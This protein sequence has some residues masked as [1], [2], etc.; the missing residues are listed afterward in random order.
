MAL[1]RIA[2]ILC[3]PCRLR[4]AHTSNFAP[5][6]CLGC[7]SR[8][9]VFPALD[10]SSVPAR[11]VGSVATRRGVE[12]ELSYTDND[13]T[14]SDD[15][16]RALYSDLFASPAQPSIETHEDVPQK[17]TLQI[18]SERFNLE[19]GEIPTYKMV[20]GRI[21]DAIAFIAPDE[22]ASPQLGLVLDSEWKDVIGAALD[23][24]DIN[25]ALKALT[26]MKSSNAVLP[27]NTD[28]HLLG[29]SY[30][31]TNVDHFTT[32]S[33]K[34]AQ[35]GYP[36][37]PDR[38]SLFIYSHLHTQPTTQLRPL[39]RIN[40]TQELIHKLEAQGTPPSQ[41]GYA[42]VIRAYLDVAK[43]SNLLSENLPD[44]S[45]DATNPF[46]AI[47]AVRDL[48]VHM[49][50]VAHPTPSLELYGL[51]IS[52]CAQGRNP[53]PLRALE[54]L[55]EVRGGLIGGKSEFLQPE[56]DI[57]SLTA[58]YNGTIRA[59]ARAG[60]RFAGD[61]FRLAKELVQLDGIPVA[62]ARTVNINPDRRTMAALMHSAKRLGELGRARWILTE[63]MRAQD[64]VLGRVEH[65]K[66]SEVILDEEIMVCTFQA[67]SAY[68]PPFRRE[69]V[70]KMDDVKDAEPQQTAPASPDA[71]PE[72]RIEMLS[73]STPHTLPQSSQDV[74]FEADAL[75]S[76]ILSNH[77]R[78]PDPLFV[79]VPVS[80][81]VVNA[82]LGVHFSHAS[83]EAALSMFSDVYKLPR[84]PEPNAYSFVGLLERL[85][86]AQKSDRTVALDEA[87]RAWAVWTKWFKR[88]EMGDV[89]PT[90]AEATPRAI[91]RVWIAIIKIY[92]LCDDMDTALTL[93]REFVT[94]YPPS[95]LKHAS[96]PTAPVN[97]SPL[98]HVGPASPSPSL[99]ALLATPA[100]RAGLLVRL[101]MPEQIAEPGVPPHLLFTDLAPLHQRLVSR[102][103]HRR[104]DVAFVTWTC[105]SYEL[106]LKRRRE[107]N[108][109]VVKPSS[110][111][112]KGEKRERRGP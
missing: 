58:C 110:S 104:A 108:L 6:R 85:A 8:R 69:G 101:T 103:P 1:A 64:Q 82:Y 93:L 57:G 40:K 7:P 66:E 97:R 75:F 90:V 92:S 53:N 83:L 34:L 45:V 41:E 37:T 18:L 86:H 61:A 47:T 17:A 71:G 5:T 76:R 12:R 73:G 109:G 77:S 21:Q 29:H 95:S 98:E 107:Q 11:P 20:V 35:A 63:V 30:L 89:D 88:V 19:P 112:P 9:N 59:C 60:P 49:R 65:P 80:A 87:R 105:K 13:L 96:I 28:L 68:R 44:T 32:L 16:L 3:S 84:M 79:H 15:Q 67:Y 23:A 25:Y 38:L 55:Q 26:A 10:N 46:A 94:K 31:R 22:T 51:A 54:L 56:V 24:A 4:T 72:S 42:H 102:H 99:S 43:E 39:E 36:P 106:Q 70:R 74:I 62:G 52:A 2:S 14:Y 33:D 78:S 27:N 50:Y 48:F 111:E 100:P 81:R 91:E